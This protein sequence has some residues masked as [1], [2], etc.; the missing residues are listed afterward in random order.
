MQSQETAIRNNST[1]TLKPDA[2][3]I[4]EIVVVGYG[5][6]RREA[7]TGSITSVTADQLSEIPAS[8]FD[9]ML[10]GKMAG[11]QIT[12]ATGQP[13]SNSN[14][15]IRGTSSIYADNEPLYVVDGIP[16]MEMNNNRDTRFTNTG[17]SIA[18]INPNDIETIT[19]LKDAASA[20]VYGSRAANGVI[21][22]TTK[23][24]KEGKSRFTARVKYGISALANDNNFRVMTDEQLL[25]Y[26]RQAVTNA[27]LNPDDPASGALYY[28]PASLLDDGTT[29]WMKHFTRLGQMQDYE[30]NVSGDS[31]KTKYYNSLSYHINEGIFYGVEFKKMN[32]RLN[33]DHELNNKLSTGTRINA[34]YMYSEDIPMQSLYYSNPSFAGMTILPWTAKYDENGN[35]NTN[36][37]ENSMTNPRATAAYDDQWEKQY[38]F[39]G[40]MYLEWKPLKGLSLKTTNAAELNFN[41]GRR[42]WSNEA[43]NYAAG[44]PTLQTMQTQYRLLT[45]SNTATYDG[46]VS[47]HT[48]RALVG[49]EA[50]K[51]DYTLNYQMSR[52]L[53]PDIPHHV[54]GNETNDM[55]YDNE[56]STL[57]SYF[58]ILDYN[59]DGRY[60]FQ[61][62][63]RYDGSSKFG[64]NNRWGLFYSIGA[65]WNLHNEY[66]MKDMNW[67]NLLKLRVSY[68][69]NGNNNIRNYRQY[70]VYTSTTYNGITGLRP[71][72]PANDDLSWEKT[73]P[74]ILESIITS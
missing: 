66:F 59:F 23:S 46:S 35:F 33:V 36:I 68:G 61:G 16:V 28:R 52:N 71:Y 7:K 70:G 31:G 18:M 1:I 6:T 40:N 50:N 13:G 44:Y 27:G 34:G 54:G 64:K 57:L 21:L 63:A 49:Q 60:Y 67:I 38:I 19:V 30:I 15:R 58:G 29:D 11:V 10:A 55:E 43:H 56:T 22:I 12:S 74:G 41:E 5:T 25:S 9:K 20:S 39:N 8:S 53:N 3:L 14:I 4:D 73:L 37:P 24:G 42:Y 45:T 62:S 2:Q 72:T 17:N 51:R 65:S 48:Y 69:L 26:Q 32:A 47:K